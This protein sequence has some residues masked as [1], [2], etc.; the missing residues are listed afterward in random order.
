VIVPTCRLGS[1]T[2]L[3]RELRIVLEPSSPTS[4]AMI[5]RVSEK[6]R[7]PSSRREP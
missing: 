5:V 4:P 3:T 7:T 6:Y 2:P 1:G